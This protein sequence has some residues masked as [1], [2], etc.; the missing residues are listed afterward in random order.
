MNGGER[1]LLAVLP[2]LQRH[3]RNLLVALPREGPFA[4]ALEGLGVET[5]A[6]PFQPGDSLGRKREALEQL[7]RHI[8]PVLLH[9]N[10]LSMGRLSGPVTANR[11]LPGLSHLRDIIRLP[12]AA[13]DDLNRHDRLLA[14]SEATRRFHCDQGIDAGRCRTLYNG[15]DTDR[16]APAAPTDF[17]HDA[18][19]IPR[20]VPL[21]G[22]VGQIGLRK[23][24]DTLLE[25]FA[26]YLE[27]RN[28]STGSLPLLL[29]VGRRWSQKQESIDYEQALHQRAAMPP[30]RGKIRFLGLREDTPAIY[31]EWSVLVHAARQEP[32][33]RVLLEAASSARAIIASDVG[34]TAEILDRDSAALIPPDDPEALSAA[35]RHMLDEPD[36]AATRQRLGEQARRRIMERFTAARSAETLAQIHEEVLAGP[37]S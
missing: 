20:N 7:L 27:Q 15:I 14:V 34:G 26:R 19:K 4:D 21:L 1:S 6:L 31:R 30:L 35:L 11:K 37:P 23:G 24:L 25:G 12:R 17:L 13:I 10:S 5:L 18:L 36:A 22:A 32:L 33:G 8:R 29:I 9:A 2:E 16:F 3:C 28:S